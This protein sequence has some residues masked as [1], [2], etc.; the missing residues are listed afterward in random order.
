MVDSVRSV[1]LGLKRH[2]I[3]LQS[4]WGLGLGVSLVCTYS[5][6]M[7]I[8]MSWLLCRSTVGLLSEGASA[9][10]AASAC[11]VR[12]SL[13][14]HL[15]SG[16]HLSPPITSPPVSLDNL[17]LRTLRLNRLSEHTTR[18]CCNGLALC[19]EDC[20][21]QEGRLGRATYLQC[22]SPE[23]RVFDGVPVRCT[24]LFPNSAM[25]TLYWQL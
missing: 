16:M 6:E 18:T 12:P 24:L 22:W 13:A 20:P 9:G 17:H 7:S 15:P 14:A 19:C 5:S 23:G 25:W 8:F 1:F 11:R 10:L 3:L 21:Q 2:C 4:V